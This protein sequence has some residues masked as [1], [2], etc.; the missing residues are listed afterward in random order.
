MRD[1]DRWQSNWQG[2]DAHPDSPVG[3]GGTGRF[4]GAR[5]LGRGFND[6]GLLSRGTRID[7]VYGMGGSHHNWVKPVSYRPVLRGR[8]V[9]TSDNDYL[10]II[11]RVGYLYEAFQRSVSRVPAAIE[12]ETGRALAEL[13][14]GL[15]SGLVLMMVVLAATTALGA[16]IGAALGAL[17][18]G[19]G[20]GPGAALGA[21]AGFELGIVILEWLGIGFLVVYVAANLY[22]I[23]NVLIDS[24]ERAWNAGSKGDGKEQVEINAAADGIARAVGILFRL[25]L[26]AI[27]LYLTAKG[28]QAVAQRVP[29]LVNNLKKSRLGEPFAK[30]IEKNYQSLI[31]DP[32]LNPNKKPPAAQADGGAAPPK[33]PP[34]KSK[35]ANKTTPTNNIKEAQKTKSTLPATTQE[36]VRTKLNDYLLNL[37][38]PVGGSK[39]KWFKE[40]LG[41]TKENMGDLAKQIKFDPAKAIQTDVTPYGTKYNQTINIIGAN[42][43]AINVP[44]AWIKNSDGIVRLVTAIPPKK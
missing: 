13:L 34:P 24:I 4:K 16:G 35:D 12:R 39:A 3:G 17:A 20:A 32:K 15:I 40:A 42:S 27:V 8:V 44:F 14:E 41:F 33:P 2:M 29:Q 9:A 18:G 11:E 22:E 5:A 21:K 1:K 7:A 36:S 30:W 37:D 28:T 38:H 10:E 19:V 43:R 31:D 26:Q 6:D 23:V 25:I